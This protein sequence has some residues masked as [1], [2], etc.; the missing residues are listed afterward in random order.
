MSSLRSICICQKFKSFL[1]KFLVKPHL[2]NIS[3]LMQRQYLSS[4]LIQHMQVSDKN[5]EKNAVFRAFQSEDAVLINDS[6]DKIADYKQDVR[7]TTAFEALD[8]LD[9]V[10]CF[11]EIH[12]DKQMNV[13][14][15]GLIGKVETLKL[16]SVRQSTIHIF[17][18]K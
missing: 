1:R 12:G 15:N 5:A 16:Q 8:S 3:T 6:D 7:K 10:N 4:L 11:S 18:K 9:A 17:F 14:L 2:M 13:M